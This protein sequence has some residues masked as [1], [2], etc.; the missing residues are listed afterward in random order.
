MRIARRARLAYE[1]GMNEITSPQPPVP[2]PRVTARALLI[3]DRIDAAGLERPDMISATPLAFRAGTYGFVAL[4]RF[5]VAVTLGLSPIEE[6]DFLR[7]LDNRVSGKRAK[8]DDE[9]AILEITGL[10]EDSIPPGGPILV[11]DMSAPRFLVL[12]DALSKHVALARDEREVNAVL[13]IIEP[14]AR[15]LARTG[16][17]PWNRRRLLKLVGQALIVQHRLSGRIAV[18]DRPDILWDRPD[19]ERFHARLG[20]EYE[21]KERSETLK[22]KLDV[23]VETGRALT[24]ILDTNRSTRLEVTIV[25]LILTEILITFYQM[26]FRI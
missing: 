16:S 9:T 17:A 6:D 25:L 15:D 2:S 11:H 5:G 24:D 26:F 10:P 19:L 18:D 7:K 23:I 4:Y 1:C 3:G 13:D 8:A 21:L 12:A 22:H 20:D 14:I